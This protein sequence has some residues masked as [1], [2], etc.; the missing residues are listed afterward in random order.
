[1]KIVHICAHFNTIIEYQ[2]LALVRKQIKQGHEVVVITS[3]YH[4]NFPNYD[5]TYKDI[6]GDRYIGTGVFYEENI[7][8]IRL[9]LKSRPNFILYLKGLRETLKNEKPDAIIC[10]GYEHGILG[11]Q[12]YLNIV[13]IIIDS[14]FVNYH[15]MNYNLFKDFLYQII[16]IL[17][18][19]Y[20]SK[21][22]NIF[23]VGVTEESVNYLIKQNLPKEKIEFIP[24]GVDTNVFHK[25][26]NLRMRVREK[27]NLKESDF[28]ICY[29]GKIEEYKGVHLLIEALKNLSNNSIYLLIIG[30]GS[31]NYL[32]NIKKMI[33]NYRLNNNVV[34]IPFCNKIE[35]NEF[36]NASDIA[37]F[38]LNITISHIEALA[39]GLPIIVEKIPAAV[40]RVKYNNGFLVERNDLK[41]L[42]EKIEILR[43][44]K[45]LREKMSL[46]AIRLAKE[47]YSW[48]II[49]DSFLKLLKKIKD[50][51][52]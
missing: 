22:N 16:K 17:K 12:S 28:V 33:H 34:F 14:H 46:N 10:H 1:M 47:C 45:E 19:Y 11:L 15:H 27:L 49:N 4:F 44:D 40:H 24:L 7:K 6:L 5:E 20:L 3:D 48:N 42:C 51:N 9:P 25:D 8:I 36:Y 21:K 2:D 18:S 39:S 30:T 26:Y 31:K 43:T 50:N 38:P 32:A 13:P 23:F 37:V 52:K 29:S 35:L 41:S